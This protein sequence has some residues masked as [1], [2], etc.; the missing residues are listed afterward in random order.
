MSERTETQLSLQ[1]EAHAGSRTLV[2]AIGT[3]IIAGWTGRDPQAVE[4][5]IAELEKLGV[6][7]P[8]TAPIFYRVSAGLLT[9]SPAIQV[10]GGDS[11]GEVEPVVFSLADG[12]WIG[13]GSDH[14]D[15]KVEAVGVTISKQMC[16]KP[17]APQLW[18]LDEV[19]DHWDQVI[20]R[21]HAV[22]DGKRRLYQQGPVAR[23]RPPQEL[24]TRY[25]GRDAIL[26]PGTA[27]FCGTLGVEGHLEPAER[28]EIELEDPVLKRRIAHAYA[29]QP[30]PVEG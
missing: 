20:L 13:V 16:A 14:T 6:K 23:L 4:A 24:M 21:S 7:R 25:L 28:F 2:A 11:S 8:K 17:V 15:R 26:P 10:A 22:I 19:A 5:H 12:L 18:R 3:L 9:T 30:L 1:G 29:I 27:M